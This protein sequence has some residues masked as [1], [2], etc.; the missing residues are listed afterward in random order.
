MIGDAQGFSGKTSIIP[1]G[2]FSVETLT[3]ATPSWK[4][5]LNRSISTMEDR[6]SRGLQHC[7][8]TCCEKGGHRGRW[9]YRVQRWH[10]C[11]DIVF[12]IGGLAY[13]TRIV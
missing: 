12:R 10:H 2:G 1:S 3:G 6:I 11:G 8:M 4:T 9:A 13:D 5:E 7:H